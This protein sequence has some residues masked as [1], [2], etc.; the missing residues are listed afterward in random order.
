MVKEQAKAMKLYRSTKDGNL[1][2]IYQN[3]LS[4]PYYRFVAVPYFPDQGK[5][6]VHEDLDGFVQVAER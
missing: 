2:V 4:F 6:Q 3:I 5:Q 1:Y